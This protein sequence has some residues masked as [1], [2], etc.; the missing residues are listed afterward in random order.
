MP[1]KIFLITAL[2]AIIALLGTSGLLA[3]GPNPRP[4]VWVDCQAYGSIVTK[5]T[6]TPDHDNFD[7]LYTTGF[8]FKDGTPL[9][10]DSA[11]GDSDYNGGRWH[12]NFL[13]GGVDPGKYS[14]ACSLADL[15]LN[16]FESTDDY[17]ECPLMPRKNQ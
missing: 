6:F 12:L 17:F 14:N 2:T 7:E 4:G 13:K 15:D 9:I 5:G 8:G 1:R 11:P 16:D 3:Q 10:S